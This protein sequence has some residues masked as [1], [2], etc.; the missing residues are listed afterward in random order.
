MGWVGV[1]MVA[2]M[3]FKGPATL[4]PRLHWADIGGRHMVMRYD[5]EGM[6]VPFLNVPLPSFS[7]DLEWWHGGAA[8]H[9]SS[10]MV[11]FKLLEA[12][13]LRQRIRNLQA[14]SG[15]AKV[16]EAAVCCFWCLC[17]G[18]RSGGRG[19]FSLSPLFL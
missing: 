12:D 8:L 9:P 14:S 4:L 16:R 5:G 6:H 10:S 17:L 3:H 11:E 13:S 15:G 1:A 7:L 19:R 18:S 2:L